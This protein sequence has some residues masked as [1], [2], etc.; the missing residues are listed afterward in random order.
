MLGIETN[1]LLFLNVRG[2]I[3]TVFVLIPLRKVIQ[4]MIV[5]VTKM[6]KRLIL[7]IKKGKLKI[8]LKRMIR[9]F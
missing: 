7:V 9:I 6:I 3:M 1:N 4:I 2:N 5:K 8:K